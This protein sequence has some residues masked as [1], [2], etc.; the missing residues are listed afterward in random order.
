MTRRV[1]TGVIHTDPNFVDS[2]NDDYR[3]TGG[4]GCIDAADGDAAPV[5]DF[6][7]E[8]RYDDLNTVN[9]GVGDPNYVDIGACEY[10]P[11]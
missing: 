11:D 7:G 5:T 8:S 3:L 2:A 10:K 4:S 6:F 9:T 1:R